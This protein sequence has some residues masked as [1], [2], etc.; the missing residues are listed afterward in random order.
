MPRLWVFL[1]W[2]GFA[3][4]AQSDKQQPKL[5]SYE[6]IIAA[7][8]SG[9]TKLV[10]QLERIWGR[11]VLPRPWGRPEAA[12]MALARLE[13]PEAMTSIGCEIYSA[14]P[15]K[16]LYAVRKLGYV[17]G[18]FAI[19]LLVLAYQRGE[20]DQLLMEGHVML[21]NIKQESDQALRR[22][23][24]REPLLS[25]TTLEGSN[26]AKWYQEHETLIQSLKPFS[27]KTAIDFAPRCKGRA[28]EK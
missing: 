15:L 24:D 22:L 25:R 23:I 13:Q 1:I 12:Q 26:W 9:D 10:P 14:S 28:P 6:D 16:R 27:S 2:I 7:G 4:F 18:G 8:I 21:G 5:D 11:A 3:A 19:K 17:G 20:N